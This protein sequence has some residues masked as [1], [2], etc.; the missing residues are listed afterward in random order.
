MDLNALMTMVQ[1][2]NKHTFND[3]PFSFLKN[4][5]PRARV[6]IYIFIYIF[7]FIYIIR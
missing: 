6:L 7:I 2:L 1:I 3:D 5:N 4:K